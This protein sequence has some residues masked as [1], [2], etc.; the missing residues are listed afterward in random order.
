MRKLGCGLTAVLGVL[1]G[2]FLLGCLGIGLPLD[3]L[4]QLALGWAFFL[5]RVVP[6]L[7]VSPAGVLTAA[8]CLIGLGVGLHLFLDWLARQ[9]AP[10]GEARPW[11]FRATLALL[12][13]FVLAFT[14]G[15]A[16]VGVSHQTAWLLNSP[17][18][19]VAGG[20]IR[21]AAARSQSQNNLKQLGIACHDYAAQNTTLPPG[22]TFDAQGRALHGWQ[23]LLLPFL[24]QDHLFRRIDL[25]RPWDDPVNAP[26]FQK[27]VSQYVSPWVAEREDPA[28]FALSHYAANAH[29]L[30]GSAGRPLAQIGGE[31]ST[32][33]TLLIGE[34]AGRF[35]PWG[36]PVNWRD[37]ARG[38]GRSPDGFGNPRGPAFPTLFVMADGS[39]REFTPDTDPKLLE[40]LA[41]PDPGR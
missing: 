3:L 38:L 4:A 22:G 27:A 14:A 18:P 21:D 41:R 40:R 12:G 33:N 1:A 17:E 2:I 19:L 7:T 26:P 9:R 23:T 28:G 10:A 15:I 34:A 36:H 8:A 20:G 25:G 13:L 39:V 5:A 31:R 32:A 37:P 24:E 29:I 30:G 16:A 6:R 35:K 11:P